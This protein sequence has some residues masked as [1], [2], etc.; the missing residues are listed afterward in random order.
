MNPPSNITKTKVIYLITKSNWGGAQR[1]VYDLATT[2]DPEHYEVSVVVGGEG[3]LIDKLHEAGIATFS[4]AHLNRDISLTQEVRLLRELWTR[5]RREQPDVLHVN[6]SKAGLLGCLLGRLAGVPRVVFTAHGWAFNED[7][8][9]IQKFLFKLFHW[10]TVLL[11]HQTIAVSHAIKQQMN[12]PL[13]QNKLMVIHHG[14]TILNFVNRLDARAVLCAAHPPLSDYQ[15]DV[16][17]LIIAELHPIKQHQQLFAAIERIIVEYPR[18]RLVCIGDGELR[19]ELQTYINDHNLSQHVFLVGAITEAATLLKA[20][21][22]F[23]LPSRSESYGYVV[24]EAGLA[25]VPVI[26]SNVG[27]ITDIVHDGVDGTL[28]NSGDQQQLTTAIT[29]FLDNP[30]SSQTMSH[31]LQTKLAD[32]TVKAMVTATSKVY[33]SR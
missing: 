8:P 30:T 25:G 16:W 12:W 1:Y 29:Q 33:R 2:L 7:R 3:V 10:L 6:S 9:A 31:T 11:S 23:I 22:L 5:L 15:A 26:A 27:G 17:L 18:V 24:H 4:L 28:F 32:R 19:A 21:D 14:R 20:A 13:V